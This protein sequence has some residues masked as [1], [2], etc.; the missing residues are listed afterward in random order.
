MCQPVQCAESH[1]TSK[2]SVQASSMMSLM[3]QKKGCLRAALQKRHLKTS[4]KQEQPLAPAEGWLT[5][6]MP[7]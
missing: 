2:A 5:A 4:L 7:A 3:P 6:S 1:S